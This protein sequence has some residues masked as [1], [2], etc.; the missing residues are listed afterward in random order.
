[1]KIKKIKAVGNYAMALFSNEII[2]HLKSLSLLIDNGTL[3]AWGENVSGQ[4]GLE[5][6]FRNLQFHYSIIPSPL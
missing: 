6:D 1:M 3:W 5:H 2:L 4:L